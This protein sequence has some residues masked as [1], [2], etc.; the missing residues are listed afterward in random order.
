[1]Q[2]LGRKQPKQVRQI[3][4]GHG[5][6]LS[7][8][9]N[10]TRDRCL[11]RKKGS[12]LFISPGATLERRTACAKQQLC[13]HTVS[14]SYENRYMNFQYW[15]PWVF[16]GIFGGK[17]GCHE[18]TTSLQQGCLISFHLLFGLVAPPPIP[19]RAK[20]GTAIKIQLQQHSV[21]TSILNPKRRL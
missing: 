7:K 11:P 20:W 9:K 18:G 17:D 14:H 6:I 2:M 10:L 21:K 12:C 8:S 13:R 19:K 3:V 5:T 4:S 1:M 16:V 15:V